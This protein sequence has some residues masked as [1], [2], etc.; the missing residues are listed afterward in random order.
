[1]G[2]WSKLIK[3]DTISAL[4]NITNA[5]SSE[6][7]WYKLNGIAYKLHHLNLEFNHL[8]SEEL[9]F[10][11][12]FKQ[13]DIFEWLSG[14]PIHPQ[15]YSEYIQIRSLIAQH[16]PA[17]QPQHILHQQQQPQPGPIVQNPVPGPSPQKLGRLPGSKSK[18][19][20]PFTRAAQYTS[21]RFT[22]GNIKNLFTG[23]C[24]E[25]CGYSI[26]TWSLQQS[27]SSQ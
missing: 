1:M 13:E 23:D 22:K 25:K 7:I 8:T 16:A 9:W 5:V 26:L 12:T 24:K 27:L 6:E 21:K 15:V 11:K 4:I 19:K 18:P 17:Q 3:R 10:W 14:S 2:A 20:D